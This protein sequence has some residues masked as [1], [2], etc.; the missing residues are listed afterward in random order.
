M[1]TLNA[2]PVTEVAAVVL[3]PAAP[4]LVPNAPP[5]TQSGADERTI[6]LLLFWFECFGMLLLGS[7]VALAVIAFSCATGMSELGTCLAGA[8]APFTMGGFMFIAATNYQQHKQLA[9]MQAQTQEMQ[10]QNEATTKQLQ[11]MQDEQAKAQVRRQQEEKRQHE[12]LQEEHCLRSLNA[13]RLLR[14]TTDLLTRNVEIEDGANPKGAVG[15]A[16]LRNR[17]ANAAFTDLPSPERLSKWKPY[18]ERLEPFIGLLREYIVS[19]D[20]IEDPEIKNHLRT[21]LASSLTKAERDVISQ[22]QEAQAQN[23]EGNRCIL[24]DWLAKNA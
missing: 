10:R 19:A 18:Q 4:P 5:G 8:A 22:L 6:N 16:L 3:P 20:R 21:Q 13:Y 17:I 11:L 9:R 7:G 24:N 2:P 1:P 12:K 14:D 15:F 23:V